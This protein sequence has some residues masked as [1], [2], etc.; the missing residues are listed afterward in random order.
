VADKAGGFREAALS[1]IRQF[2]VDRPQLQPHVD[3][4]P[5]YLKRVH[6][7]MCPEMQPRYANGLPRNH[8]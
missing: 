1:T 5:E 8:W 3:G 7:G 2:L 6:M 4:W